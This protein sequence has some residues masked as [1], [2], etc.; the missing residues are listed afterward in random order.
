VTPPERFATASTRNEWLPEYSP[1]G[2]RIAF[3]SDRFDDADVFRSNP[4]GKEVRRLTDLGSAFQGEWSPDGDYYAFGG[5]DPA[6]VQDIWVINDTNGAVRNLTPDEYDDAAPSWSPDG[7]WVYYLSSRGINGQILRVLS[8]GGSSILVHETE[9]AVR[10]LR[11]NDEDE[12]LFWRESQIWS[13][14]SDLG[15]ETLVMDRRMPNFFNWC[16]W[17]DNIVYIS[18][19]ENGETTI[20]RFDRTCGEQ[21]VLHSLGK[22]VETRPGLTVSPD[23]QW[24][25]FAIEEASGDLMLVENFY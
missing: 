15:V 1:D 8:D 22:N 7:R 9:G 5:G 23:G 24:I 25:L 10:S 17:K 13:L 21:F 16:L 20:E 3:V 14:D 19:N 11:V 4:D 6:E 2:S 18:Q 12:V